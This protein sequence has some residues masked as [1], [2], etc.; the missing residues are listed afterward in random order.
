MI[1]YDQI[2]ALGNGVYGDIYKCKRRS[3]NEIVCVKQID[4]KDMSIDQRIACWNEVKVS[5]HLKHPNIIAYHEAFTDNDVFAIVM[6]YCDGGDL[7]EWIYNNHHEATEDK[8]LFIFVQIAFGI[9]YLHTK[10]KI[11]HR[12]L[13]PKNIFVCENGRIVLGDFGIAK[14]LDTSSGLAQSLIGSPAYMSPEIFEGKMYGYKADVWSLGC[15]LYELLTSRCPF[16][17]SS[18]PALVHKITQGDYEELNPIT[19]RLP[20]SNN[21]LLYLEVLLDV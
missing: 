1:A 20:V 18:Y 16:R 10:H 8:I 3:D 15:I 17:A 19:F 14:S 12:D 2:Q 21:H 13:K 6:E 11:L 4:V 5:E 9:H 7:N